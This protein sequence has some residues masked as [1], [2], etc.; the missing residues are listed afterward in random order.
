[1]SFDDA[2]LVEYLLGSCDP[3]LRERIDAALVEDATLRAHVAALADDL[4]LVT[5]TEEPV[6][7]PALRDRVL[8]AHATD[9]VGALGGRLGE[10]LDLAGD[11]LDTL[12][13]DI[14]LAPAAPWV[15][16]GIPGVSMLAVTTGPGVR[17][18][19]HIMHLA[20]GAN[21][22][23]HRHLGRE[24][25]LIL[26]GYAAE[27]GGREVGP[28]DL[29]DSAAQSQH[30]FDILVDAPCLFAVVLEGEIRFV[31]PD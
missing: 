10:F 29:I 20:P 11:T 18:A 7:S 6:P 26:D 13:T 1:M 16:T 9:P 22:P 27:S 17:G 24:R 21:V 14:R 8:A 2:T 19:A 5:A 15:A 23:P 3:A 12:I 31:E 4:A 30:H 28:G 25:M